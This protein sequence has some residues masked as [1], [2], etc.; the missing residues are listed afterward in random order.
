M[1]QFALPA[2]CVCVCVWGGGGRSS[3]PGAT[4]LATF[5]TQWVN[6]VI[7]MGQSGL[8]PIYTM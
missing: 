5:I 6:V 2:L 7:A 8:G 4:M 3:A 1:K